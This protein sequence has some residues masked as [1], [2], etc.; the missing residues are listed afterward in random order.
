MQI[1]CVCRL[2]CLTL[3]FCPIWPPGAQ[4]SVGRLPPVNCPVRIMKG[5]LPSL[6]ILCLQVQPLC[7]ASSPSSFLDCLPGFSPS[8]PRPGSL[9]V[10]LKVTWEFQV[11]FLRTSC[12]WV[13]L[14]SF[15]FFLIVS[16]V[17]VFNWSVGIF[18]WKVVR[19]TLGFWSSVLLFL[20][21][22]EP[23]APS[24][25]GP[26][27]PGARVLGGGLYPEKHGGWQI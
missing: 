17:S 8:S 9:T 18:N 24:A 11:C 4:S 7:H 6:V 21:S 5:R 25:G 12:S 2:V 1:S 27:V 22:L 16:T 3:E 20:L 10:N 19:D 13:S 15:F 14:F 26:E 23:K